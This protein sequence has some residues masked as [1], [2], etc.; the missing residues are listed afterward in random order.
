MLAVIAATAGRRPKVPPDNYDENEV[1]EGW[2]HLSRNPARLHDIMLCLKPFRAIPGYR[3]VVDYVKPP[4]ELER[5]PSLM[6][7]QRHVNEWARRNGY[8]NGRIS[9]ERHDIE[10]FVGEI[11]S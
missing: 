9:E 11:K 6:H 1:Q 3:T 8:R 5:L 2:E 4:F 10:I 7:F